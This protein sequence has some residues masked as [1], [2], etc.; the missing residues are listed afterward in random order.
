NA[1]MQGL[2][3]LG[4]AGFD[5][6][7][8]KQF[9]AVI[10]TYAMA[11]VLLYLYM[12]DDE[13]YDEA[14]QWERDTYHLFKIPG[15]DVMY[16]FP[17]PFEV[18]FVA[19]MAERAVEQMV[20]DKAHGELFFER[21][22]HGITETLSFNPVPQMIMPAVEVWANQNTFTN[23]Q[24]ESEAM[25]NLSPSERKRAW[26]SETAIAMSKG[27]NAVLW[28]DV[29]LSP[30]QIEHL[31]NGYFGWMG[32]TV[33]ESTDMII[34]GVGL[35]PSIPERR[36]QDYVLV[37]RF[38][39]TGPTRGTRYLSEFYDNLHDA[40]RAYA[41][42][43][44]AAQL[45]DQEKAME[46]AEK[47]KDALGMR[48]AYTGAQKAVSRINKAILIIR[49]KDIPSDEK[50]EEIEMLN[51]MKNQIAKRIIEKTEERK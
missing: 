45:G 11:S 30:L 1:R 46:L 39:R 50:R 2:S 41:N 14:P 13:D 25:K 32:G 28:D 18:G 49:S 12:K 5:P 24:I 9:A 26:T 22:W 4:R 29:V 3:K 34:R 10:G 51:L 35:A 23:R 19:S 17:R 7:Q 36:V 6:A 31:V 38:A 33:L 21:A 40:N 47:N 20:N 44:F 15:S 48:N 8:R 37:G 16:R 43:R 42:I 27:F